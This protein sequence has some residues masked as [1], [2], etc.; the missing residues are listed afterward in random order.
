MH[1]SRGPPGI[2]CY[3]TTF[4]SGARRL[5]SSRDEL[6]REVQ[7]NSSPLGRFLSLAG[8]ASS[9]PKLTEWT[10]ERLRYLLDQA[11]LVRVRRNDFTKEFLDIRGHPRLKK[12][13]TSQWNQYQMRRERRHYWGQ[14]LCCSYDWDSDLSKSLK[15]LF[16][17]SKKTLIR[18]S[19]MQDDGRVKRD[20]KSSVP[21]VLT[22]EYTDEKGEVRHKTFRAD[23]SLEDVTARNHALDD[24]TPL[25]SAPEGPV[26]GSSPSES[27][28]EYKNILEH[29]E[30]NRHARRKIE[31]WLNDGWCVEW[32]WNH[33]YRNSEHQMTLRRSDK[34]LSPFPSPWN[35]RI[36]LEFPTTPKPPWYPDSDCSSDSRSASDADSDSK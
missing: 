28:L 14:A 9:Q 17:R 4:L 34:I 15:R 6:S 12:Y 24:S 31:A 36:V 16:G 20:C 25:S 33:K 21:E 8:H 19:E 2:C 23:P 1:Y 35:E 29:R 18:L 5:L 11:H 3:S 22:V 26:A 27:M 30:I 10:E 7:A 32:E 13:T